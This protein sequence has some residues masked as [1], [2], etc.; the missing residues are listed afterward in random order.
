M[1]FYYICNYFLY[2]LHIITNLFDK[3]YSQKIY[4]KNNNIFFIIPQL[5]I[6]NVILW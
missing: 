2:L 1:C 3:F 4:Y 6:K 5:K